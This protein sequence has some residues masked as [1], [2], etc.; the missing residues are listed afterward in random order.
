MSGL[1]NLNLGINLGDV[2]SLVSTFFTQFWYLIAFGIALIA[3]P[4]VVRA[5]KGAAGGGGK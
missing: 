2:F 5:V 1:E 4:R 3:F